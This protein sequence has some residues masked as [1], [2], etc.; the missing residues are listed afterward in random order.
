VRLLAE[1]PHRRAWLRT[2]WRHVLV[3][4]FQDIN[5]AQAVLIDLLAGPDG[6]PHAMHARPGAAS[7]CAWFRSAG[8]ATAGMTEAS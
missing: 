5:H 7:R 6:N 3:D 2:K 8:A 1:Q 4:E